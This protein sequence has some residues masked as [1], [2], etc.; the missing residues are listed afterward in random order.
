MVRNAIF[1]IVV[2]GFV[3]GLGPWLVTRYVRFDWG[4]WTVPVVIVAAGLILAGALVLLYGVWRFAAEGRGTP[5]P[6]APTEA[7]VVAGPYRYVRNPMYLAVG[8]IILGQVFL[9]LMPGIVIYAAAFV[10]AVVSFVTWYEEPT[11][12]RTF[13][14]DYEAYKAAVPGWWPRR[15]R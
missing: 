10:V 11:L 2:P 9:F 13:G 6:T 14:A 8:A 12:L 7:L 5:S 3:A 1:V 4:A 15:P